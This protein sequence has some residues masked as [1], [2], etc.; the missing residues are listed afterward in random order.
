MFEPHKFL[1]G[2]EKLIDQRVARALG[3]PDPTP[4]IDHADVV[5]NQLLELVKE[6]S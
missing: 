1:S 4:Q 6:L 3:K 5:Y 2:L